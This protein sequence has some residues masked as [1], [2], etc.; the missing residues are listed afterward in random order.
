MLLLLVEDVVDAGVLSCKR[1]VIGST[2]TTGSNADLTWEY[3][4]CMGC[5]V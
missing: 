4:I 2:P 3:D 1:K 5:L